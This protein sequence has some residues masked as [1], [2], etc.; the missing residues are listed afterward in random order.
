[1]RKQP[2]TVEH[3][4]CGVGLCAHEDVVVQVR[5]AMP[6]DAVSEADD[7]APSTGLIAILTMLTITHDECVLFEVT[8]RRPHRIAMGRDD[9]GRVLGVDCQQDRNWPGRGD[10]DVVTLYRRALRRA[11]HARHLAGISSV[12][13]TT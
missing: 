4:A 2:S 11:Q 1:M 10:H 5:L 8:N 6:V 3:G 7:A 9:T 13:V 12:T